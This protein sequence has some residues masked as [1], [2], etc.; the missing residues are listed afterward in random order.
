MRKQTILIIV[1]LGLFVLTLI[2]GEG[3]RASDQQA[4][5]EKDYTC[6]VDADCPTCVG[7][8]AGTNVSFFDE[9]SY[10]KCVNGKCHL[11]SSCLNWDCNNAGGCTSIRQSLFD[12]LIAYFNTH[13][14]VLLLMIGLGVAWWQLR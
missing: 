9:L 13:I 10:A 12:N 3:T 6:S 4:I 7:G 5:V 11:S 14:L 8:I 2:P 1:I